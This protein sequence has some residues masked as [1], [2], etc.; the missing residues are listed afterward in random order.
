M[1]TPNTLLD[2]WFGSETDDARL[3]AQQAALWWGKSP[4]TDADIRTRFA[5]LLPKAEAGALDSWRDSAEGLLA[6][7]LLTDQFPRNSYRDTA[8][9][10]AFDRMALQLTLQ[11]L[12]AGQDQM[13]S[14]IRRV[15]FYLPL[16]HAED[17][18]HQAHS[19]QLFR[20][21][22][23][24]VPDSQQTVFAGFADYAQRHQA[25]LARFGRFPHRNALLGRTSS[26]EENAFLAQPGS[27][28]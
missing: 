8:R 26:A 3:A 16:E 2:Y 14:P 15:F 24:T 22:A 9:A 21:L 19:V 7:I 27:S 10:F 11:G 13:L 6:L 20:T 17:S 25:I 28:F 12:S 23:D 4:A 18:A 1:E 5:P